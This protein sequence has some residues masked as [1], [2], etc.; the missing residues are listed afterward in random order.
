[1]EYMLSAGC[2]FIESENLNVSIDFSKAI[3]EQFRIS[4]GA[5]REIDLISHTHNFSKQ[6]IRNQKAGLKKLSK[7]L[8]SDNPGEFS[9][10]L[11][12]GKN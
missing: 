6:L 1:M 10:V 7:D 4:D 11:V 5:G 8:I 3:I 12:F 2:S 9:K